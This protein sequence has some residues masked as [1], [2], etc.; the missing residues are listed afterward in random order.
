MNPARWLAAHAAGSRRGIAALGALVIAAIVGLAG[1]DIV[2]SHRATVDDTGRE[3]VAEARVIAE[4]TARSI[5]AV[6]VVLRHLAEQHR[7]GNLARLGAA[8]LHALLREQAVG[9][10]QA[11]GLALHDARGEAL[12]FSWLEPTPPISSNAAARAAFQAAA[13]DR[14]QRGFRRRGA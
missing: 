9:L 13:R 6:D 5:Q 3:L 1:Y 11:D 4:Q 10:V 8:E 2:R 12:A 14:A 7:R